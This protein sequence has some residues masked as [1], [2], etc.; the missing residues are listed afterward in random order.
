MTLYSSVNRGIYGHMARAR[1]WAGPHY[2]R[3][4]HITEEYILI[5]LSTEEYNAIY[6]SALYSSFVSSAI[7]LGYRAMFLGYN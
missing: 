2:I 4:L 6:L 1:G 7:F 5:F 3:W